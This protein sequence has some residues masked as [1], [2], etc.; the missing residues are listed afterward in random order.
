MFSWYKY[1]IVIFFF[2]FF[3]FFFIFFFFFG[4]WSG[5]LFLIAPFPD[6]CLLVPFYDMFSWYKYLVVNLVFPT[7]VWSGNL[8]LIAP[9]PDFCL[10]VLFETFC[11]VRANV[12][13]NLMIC[14]CIL[15]EQRVV[16]VTRIP[17]TLDGCLQTVTLR[18][19]IYIYINIK[20]FFIS[21]V[22]IETFQL[23]FFFS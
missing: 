23:I 13:T 17:P 7:S 5:T 10:L 9:F 22:K 19:H 20:R 11:F 21:A 14:T 6:L 2:F 1:L 8:F 4:F 15:N 16:L 12:K 3:L 18:K